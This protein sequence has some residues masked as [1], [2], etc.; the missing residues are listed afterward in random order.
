MRSFLNNY[1]IR[2]LIRIA[3]FGFPY[4]Y[5]QPLLRDRIG[6]LLLTFNIAFRLFLNKLSFGLIP[7]SSIVLLQNP[8]LTY[9]QVMRRADLTTAGLSAA[10]LTLCWKL[11]G[12]SLKKLVGFP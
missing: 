6:H 11:F 10:A 1:K 2:A 8:N 9:R 3:R 7:T 5:R 4:Q 12:T